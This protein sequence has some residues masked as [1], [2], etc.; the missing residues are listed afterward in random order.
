MI[1]LNNPLPEVS[2]ELS[3]SDKNFWISFI[4]NN[5]RGRLG[6]NLR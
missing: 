1:T 4:L 2:L 3:I 5:H 6:M